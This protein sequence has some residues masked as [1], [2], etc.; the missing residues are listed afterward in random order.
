LDTEA[1]HHAFW[2]ENNAH[3][4]SFAKQHG[5]EEFLREYQQRRAQHHWDYTM[6]WWKRNIAL[7]VAEL[8]AWHSRNTIKGQA[9]FFDKA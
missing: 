4:L 3:Y 9:A 1:H 5:Q 2:K 8:R 7:L 6:W